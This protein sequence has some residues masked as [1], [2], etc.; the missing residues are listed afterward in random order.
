[1]KELEDA[2]LHMV[3]HNKPNDREGGKKDVY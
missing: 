1:L 2:E 3:S